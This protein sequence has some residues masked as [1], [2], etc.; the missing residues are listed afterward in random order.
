MACLY[1]LINK[2]NRKAYV[3]QSVRKFRFRLKQHLQESKVGRTK[4]NRA[5]R[6]YGI[7]GFDCFSFEVSEDSLDQLEQDFIVALNSIT[8]GYNL[9]SGGHSNKHHSGATKSKMSI[10]AKRWL[11]DHPR[12]FTDETRRKLSEA[13]VGERNGFYGKHHTLETIKG[14]S[15]KHKGKIDSLETRKKRSQ[16]AKLAWSKRRVKVI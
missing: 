9:E 15:E 3:G 13:C 10:S 2:V 11:K 8:N 7:N 16:S 12:I 6:K 1:I 5:L 14:N 4:I